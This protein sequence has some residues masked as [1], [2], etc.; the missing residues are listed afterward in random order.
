MTDE[1]I[2]ARIRLLLG[3]I[4][5]ETLPDAVIQ[6]FLDTWEYSLD[7]E[8][9]PER[10]PVVVYNTLISCVR[11]L[12]VQEITNGNT[13]VT[14][15]LEKIGDE[16][17]QIKGGSTFSSWEDFLNYL[18]ANP[19]YVDPTLDIVS[20][21]VVI[22]GTRKDEFCRVKSNPNSRNG[23]MEQGIY[24]HCGSTGCGGRRSPFLVSSRN[25]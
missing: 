4:D 13:S 3:G 11:W 21:L 7:V 18:L 16:T 23:Y 6:T 10:M 25:R 17:I 8:N 12:M 5:E 14:E 15:R 2:I 19:D 9:H 22:G 1:E 20:G 24:P